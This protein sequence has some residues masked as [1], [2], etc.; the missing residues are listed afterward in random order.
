MKMNMFMTEMPN[1]IKREMEQLHE[2]IKPLAKK[3]SKYTFWAF[4]LVVLSFVNLAFLLFFNPELQSMAILVLFAIIGAFGLALY[5][6]AKHQKREIHRQSAAY[7]IKRIQ[8]SDI[9][10]TGYQ[11]RYIRLIKAQ[12]VHM[13]QYFIRFLEE[14]KKQVT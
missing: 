3:V 12:P 14:E 8:K 10:S 2:I 5:K 1:F 11:K 7:I 4:F 13:M 9:V 6:E